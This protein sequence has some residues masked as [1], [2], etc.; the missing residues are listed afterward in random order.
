VKDGQLLA[1]ISARELDHQISQ[2]EATL[3]QLK[4]TLL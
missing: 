3:V 4:E 1:A 2:N